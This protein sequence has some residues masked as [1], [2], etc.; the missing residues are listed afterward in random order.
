MIPWTQFPTTHFPTVTMNFASQLE[1]QSKPLPPRQEKEKKSWENRTD[2][3]TTFS[4]LTIRGSFITVNHSFHTPCPVP[5]YLVC[6]G[7]STDSMVLVTGHK[8]PKIRV[9][10]WGAHGFLTIYFPN[11]CFRSLLACDKYIKDHVVKD[12]Q[13][14]G[15]TTLLKTSA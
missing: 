7:S 15:I 12:F 11:P 6:D 3:L 9:V 5:Y 10:S 2:E 4:K 14:R 13:Q 1:G 8:W